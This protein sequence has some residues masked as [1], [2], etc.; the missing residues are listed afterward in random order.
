MPSLWFPVC[1]APELSAGGPAL[2]LLPPVWATPASRVELSPALRRSSDRRLAFSP[3]GGRA[4]ST[5]APA[6]EA[7]AAAAAAA[8]DFTSL[9]AQPPS[10]PLADDGKLTRLRA[11]RALRALRLIKMVSK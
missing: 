9:D 3:P 10:S 4:L 2:E 1:R 6:A 11:L 5:A 8:S 7:A